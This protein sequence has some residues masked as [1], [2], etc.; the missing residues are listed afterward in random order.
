MRNYLK[1]LPLI[2]ATA[3]GTPI[4]PLPTR[5]AASETSLQKIEA[6]GVQLNYLDQ[7]KGAPVI[8]VHGALDDY[9]VWQPQMEAF[10]QRHRTVAY[11]RR[12]NYP[13]PKVDLETHYSARVD[14]DDL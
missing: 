5:A 6:N 2:A 1:T 4:L 3:L 12:Y 13:N 11:S 9:R 14:A 7:G 10:S 8:F